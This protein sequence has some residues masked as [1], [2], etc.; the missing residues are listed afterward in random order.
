[1]RL[2]LGAHR[3][4]QPVPV[5]NRLSCKGILAGCV[6]FAPHEMVVGPV[7]SSASVASQKGWTRDPVPWLQQGRRMFLRSPVDQLDIIVLMRT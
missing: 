4:M 1:M 6:V 5:R 3:F 2:N 7:S